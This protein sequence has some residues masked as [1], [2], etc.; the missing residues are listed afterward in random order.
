MNFLK[1]FNLVIAILFQV[2][3]VLE[4]HPNKPNQF[5]PDEII[6]NKRKRRSASSIP[7]IDSTAFADEE[8]RNIPFHDKIRLLSDSD[9][10]NFLTYDSL[11]V[12]RNLGVKDYIKS[13]PSYDYDS[14]SFSSEFQTSYTSNF[15]FDIKVRSQA[16]YSINRFRQTLASENG[17]QYAEQI[18]QSYENTK[19]KYNNFEANRP[20]DLHEKLQKY[21]NEASRISPG[22][23]KVN[24]R[25]RKNNIRE[26]KEALEEYKKAL[27]N[28][29]GHYDNFVQR[30]LRP[31]YYYIQS[32]LQLTE[33]TLLMAMGRQD[34]IEDY[35]L[36]HTFEDAIKFDEIAIK[37]NESIIHKIQTFDISKEIEN[38]AFEPL[39][40]SKEKL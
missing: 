21:K 16:S 15:T 26:G 12:A 35:I 28:K 24:S 27:K 36:L 30:V 10:G 5:N 25:E 14:T 40:K 18:V 17:P 7:E 19:Q 29:E 33:N 6:A 20:H 3:T 13:L 39:E 37:I 32:S 4:S 1:Y 11:K 2:S 34:I 22:Q 23:L 8:A 31:E 9:D 38:F